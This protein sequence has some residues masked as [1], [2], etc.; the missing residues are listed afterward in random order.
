MID[1]PNTS[2][3]PSN[4]TLMSNA[5]QQTDLHS[6]QIRV[7][8]TDSTKLG[9]QLLVGALRRQSGIEPLEGDRSIH[10]FEQS[11]LSL[12]PD[13]V[14]VGADRTGI[15]AL[16]L[17]LVRIVESAPEKIPIVIL[18]GRSTGEGIL[19][20]FRVGAGG[21]LSGEDSIETLG[22]CI[23]C[24]GKG[25][26]FIRS[27]QLLSMAQILYQRAAPMTTREWTIIR[28]IAEEF[29]NG[30]ISSSTGQLQAVIRELIGYRPFDPRK[31]KPC[32]KESLQCNGESC[33]ENTIPILLSS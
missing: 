5:E 14:L 12:Q 15:S 6:E 7:L 22:E 8:V 23:R 30:D 19:T 13:V 27:D 9:T 17:D 29:T 31:W 25:R 26:L 16:T 11:L 1:C 28:C 24:V 18:L 2:T 20:A 33:R 4:S 10:E 3:I 21:V 32:G